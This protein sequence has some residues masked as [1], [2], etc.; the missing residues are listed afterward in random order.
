M[1]TLSTLVL[2]ALL[3]LAVPAHAQTQSSTNRMSTGSGTVNPAREVDAGDLGPARS[4]IGK[5]IVYRYKGGTVGTI[6][7]VVPGDD[8]RQKLVVD[9]KDGHRQVMLD[10][11]EVD[12]RGNRIQLMI[13]PEQVAGLPNYQG[14]MGQGTM[15]QSGMGRGMGQGGMGQGNMSGNRPMGTAQ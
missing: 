4:L 5:P 3:L 14:G 13:D 12:R 10:S 11:S 1:R 15:G 8:G 2:P 6:R 7:D 9:L